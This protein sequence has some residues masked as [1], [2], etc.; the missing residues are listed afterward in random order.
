MYFSTCFSE[1]GGVRGSREVDCVTD[2][3]TWTQAGGTRSKYLVVVLGVFLGERGAGKAGHR[4]DV[5]FDMYI[6]LA[7]DVSCAQAFT[8]H[9]GLGPHD[10]TP[11][12]K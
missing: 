8:R 10:C 9:G 11:R 12:R 1:N 5:E 2:G 3:T 6:G 7:S 4:A